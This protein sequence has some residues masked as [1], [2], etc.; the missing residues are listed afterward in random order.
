MSLTYIGVY[1][2]LLGALFQYLGIP[3]VKE[4]I[5]VF[6]TVALQLV[7]GFLAFYGRYRLG[8][9]SKLGFRSQ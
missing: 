3:V 4:N 6:V 1:G 8:S 9:V 5:E 2:A 7:G